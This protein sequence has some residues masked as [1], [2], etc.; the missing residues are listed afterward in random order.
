ME[1]SSNS[2]IGCK[3]E[4]EDDCEYGELTDDRD[5]KKYKTVKIG[6]QWW[7]AENLNYADSVKT[8][9]LLKRNWCYKNEPDSCSKYGRLY[10]WAAAIDSVTLATDADNPQDCGY[11]ETCTLP[12]RVQ[13]ICPEGWHLPTQSEWDTL[14]TAVGGQSNA[15][16][17]LKSQAGWNNDDYGDSG[18]GTDS[19]GFSA[20]PAGNRYDGNFRYRGYGADFWSATQDNKSLDDEYDA[21]GMNLYNDRGYAFLSDYGKDYAFS[22]RCVK[23]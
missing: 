18:N 4:T 13:G 10:T 1:S 21:Y 16:K 20:L 2:K 17:V 14:F 12:A 23:D 7:M 8:P 3:T 6:D 11:G 19:F 5:D 9:S 15:G 22:V